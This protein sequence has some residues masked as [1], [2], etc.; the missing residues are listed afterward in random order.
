MINKNPGKVFSCIITASTFRTSGLLSVSG[1]WINMNDHDTP[2]QIKPG[3]EY[4]PAFRYILVWQI[5]LC[6]YA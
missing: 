5:I 2:D 6:R 1:Y 4:M 3:R